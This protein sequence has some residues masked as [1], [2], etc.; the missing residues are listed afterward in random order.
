MV[1]RKVNLKIETE[2][3]YQAERGHNPL[4]RCDNRCEPVCLR[5]RHLEMLLRAN[6]WPLWSLGWGAL[7]ESLETLVE[8]F[9]SALIHR[10]C[11]PRYQVL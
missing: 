9:V 5:S 4:K 1:L 7:L 8:L 10:I 11:S 2:A 3:Y 6:K